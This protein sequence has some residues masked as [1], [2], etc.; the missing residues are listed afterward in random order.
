ML[1]KNCLWTICT[2]AGS[3]TEHVPLYRLKALYAAFL[4]QDPWLH[5]NR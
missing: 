3:S 4:G 2:W 1:I 5:I